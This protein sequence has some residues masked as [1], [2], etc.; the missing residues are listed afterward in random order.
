LHEGYKVRAIDNFS[1]GKKENLKSLFNQSNFE[2]MDGDIRDADTCRKA[3]ENVDYVLHQAAFGSV[4]RSMVYPLMYE[5]TNIKGTSNMMDA[6][7]LA[8]VKRFVFA[9]SSAVYGDSLDLPLV[10]GREGELLSPYALTK[11]VNEKYGRL[12]TLVYGLEC[13][14]LRY[15]NVFGKRQIQAPN[16]PR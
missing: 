13:I 6:A 11:K 2:F 14:G 1:T 10:E 15:F 5:D 7:R 12:Y 8:G 4:P 3:V 16:M 9:S